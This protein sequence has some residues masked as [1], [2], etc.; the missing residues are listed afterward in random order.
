M[1]LILRPHK[2]V[3]ISNQTGKWKHSIQNYPMSS[4]WPTRSPRE[5]DILKRISLQKDFLVLGVNTF[6]FRSLEES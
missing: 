6:F 4:L 5:V 3:H 1:P 2:I